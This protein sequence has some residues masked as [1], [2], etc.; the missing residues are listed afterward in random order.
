MT[1][2][3]KY[4][5]KELLPTYKLEKTAFTLAEVLITLG[6]IGVVAAMTIP[7]LLTAHKKHVIESKLERAVS[8]INQT[9]KMSESENGEMETWDRSL[10]YKEFIEKYIQP[11]IKIM[12]ICEG[13]NTCGYKGQHNWSYLNGQNGAYDSPFNN[14]R[15]PFI[16]MDGIL[17][18]FGYKSA[19][20]TVASNNDKI[21]IIDINGS[22]RPNKFGQDVF[23]LYRI[24]E[25]D[26]IIPY[27]ADKGH[28]TIRNNCSKTGNGMYCAAWIRENGWKIPNGYPLN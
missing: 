27:G 19:N 1:E 2:R 5:R 6:I 20:T 25:A 10:T 24:E 3:D 11:Y 21:I 15:V 22:Q 7:N 26:S 8:V 12:Q 9:I 14:E 4:N 18:V 13:Y 28:N 16:S 17:Y 23:F